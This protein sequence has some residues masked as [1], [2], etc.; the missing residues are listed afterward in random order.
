MNKLILDES[1]VN[2]F[3]R[4]RYIERTG[5]KLSFI[6]ICRRYERPNAKNFGRLEEKNSSAASPA[7]KL[8][9]RMEL[10]G[11]REPSKVYILGLGMQKSDQI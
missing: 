8:G 6:I 5:I 9:F 4:R 11:S 1:F 10:Q 2:D 3:R 7:R